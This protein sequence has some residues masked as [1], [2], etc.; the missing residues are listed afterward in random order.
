MN[1]WNDKN[2]A[3]I[4]KEE[5]LQYAMRLRAKF[6]GIE[7]M[8]PVQQQRFLTAQRKRTAE[9]EAA[10]AGAE[11][12]PEGGGG[13]L[14]S[15]DRGI[16]AK[17]DR[18]GQGR[19]RSPVGD[20]TQVEGAP[21]EREGQ[22]GG[23]TG[24]GDFGKQVT[25]RLAE[26][27]GQL[28]EGAD[29]AGEQVGAA[30]SE[31]VQAAYDAGTTP[32]KI[33][34]DI[35]NAIK[36]PDGVA[37]AVADRHPEQTGIKYMQ[38]NLLRVVEAHL[39]SRAP[40]A[41]D[42]SW[43]TFAAD[44]SVEIAKIYGLGG[45]RIGMGAAGWAADTALGVGLGVL[46]DPYDEAG[47][48]KWLDDA[49]GGD[50]PLLSWIADREGDTAAER[51]AK[52][53][54]E[55]VLV[56]LVG[57]GALDSILW[58]VQGGKKATGRPSDPEGL[59]MR[60]AIQAGDREA[61]VG[62]ATTMD[63]LGAIEA[64]IFKVRPEWKG[65]MERTGETGLPSVRP[66]RS[67]ETEQEWRARTEAIRTE[68]AKRGEFQPRRQ[69]ETDAEYAKR[70]QAMDAEAVP[71][72]VDVAILASRTEELMDEGLEP[73]AARAQA[74]E[75]LTAG[76]DEAADP[77][78]EA[79]DKRAAELMAEDKTGTLDYD[80]A[81]LAAQK[82]ADEGT[83]K[84]PEKP[85]EGGDAAPAPMVADEYRARAEGIQKLVT[86]L[87][88]EGAE[89]KA[90][91]ARLQERLDATDPV[92]K[93][94]AALKAGEEAPV[95]PSVVTAGE[96]LGIVPNNA[97]SPAETMRRALRISRAVKEGAA[98]KEAA[99]AEANAVLAD[100]AKAKTPEM[101]AMKRDEAAYTEERTLSDEGAVDIGLE[102][103]PEALAETPLWTRRLEDWSDDER[104]G[105][106]TRVTE[107][108]PKAE[109]GTT[110]GG[111]VTVRVDGDDYVLVGERDGHLLFDAH[112]W[113][114]PG[115]GDFI[116]Q[117]AQRSREL[118]EA[119]EA[120][121]MRF[122][123]PQV[124]PAGSAKGV[125]KLQEAV[126]G[127]EARL[128]AGAAE[129]RKAHLASLDDLKDRD[130]FV[131]H[132]TTPEVLDGTL[133]KTLE[134]DASGMP[135]MPGPRP[136]DVSASTRGS[137]PEDY[138]LHR[139]NVAQLSGYTQRQIDD[140]GIAAPLRDM[141]TPNWAK[142]RNSESVEAWIES[143]AEV[144][145]ASA[146]DKV[147]DM[148]VLRRIAWDLELPDLSPGKARAWVMALNDSANEVVAAA[149]MAVN[150]AAD[151]SMLWDMQV[152]LNRHR[153]ML[154]LLRGDRTQADRYFDGVDVTR[155]TDPEQDVA[156]LRARMEAEFGGEAQLVETANALNAKTTDDG[157]HELARTMVDPGGP[158]PMKRWAREVAT[159][160]KAGMLSGP[161][162]WV[163]IAL[164]NTMTHIN[165]IPPMWI[166]AGMRPFLRD[167]DD[168]V[169]YHE[170]MGDLTGRVA[171]LGMGIK[172]MKAEAE[173]GLWGGSR[174]RSK[175]EEEGLLKHWKSA[176]G[177]NR[178]DLGE[179][180]Y[181]EQA[182]PNRTF[183][184]QLLVG[185]DRAR[186]V[187][188][189][190]IGSIDMV[191]KGTAIG[192]Y[193]SGRAS[194]EGARQGLT[195][196]AFRNHVARRLRNPPEDW[197]EEAVKMG[198]DLTFMRPFSEN[199]RWM[200][201][202]MAKM[203]RAIER[204]PLLL[205]VMAM[206][207]RTAP[208]RSLSYA[209]DHTPVLGLAQ[210]RL[211]QQWAAGGR[212]KQMMIAR[213]LWGG[214]LFSGMLFGA[215]GGVLSGGGS[216]E[217][218]M[219][220]V[221]RPAYSLK[222]GDGWLGI[223]RLDPLGRLAGFAGDV[224]EIMSMNTDAD[225]NEQL[226]RVVNLLVGS[227]QHHMVD[228]SF[229]GSA[230]EF[231]E[232]LTGM[233]S[234]GIDEHWGGHLL[235]FAKRQGERFVPY[236]SLVRGIT[237]GVDPVYRDTRAVKEEGQEW[238]DYFMQEFRTIKAL[239]PGLSADL[240]PQFDQWGQP[241][242][243]MMPSMGE[244][245]PQGLGWS[246]LSPLA[247]TPDRSSP[248]QEAL[249]FAQWAPPPWEKSHKA[250]GYSD[251][252]RAAIAGTTGPL[253]RR[254]LDRHL[255][256]GAFDGY[257]RVQRTGN[258]EEVRAARDAAANE[259]KVLYN[260]AKR[261]GQRMVHGFATD[262]QEKR[263]DLLLRKAREDRAMRERIRLT[264]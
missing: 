261:Q 95:D 35:H 215:F 96:R 157:V 58:A 75:E 66:G 32:N 137:H 84:V 206:P 260:A 244:D 222:V 146:A 158:T 224:A 60:R 52:N 169:N 7:D 144:F 13:L 116:E 50:T 45:F 56:A 129:R 170:A 78:A 245:T 12:A 229:V 121:V 54:A 61:V 176:R 194:K 49:G 28:A 81:V 174:Y 119:S 37:G 15:L 34:E 63:E 172:M 40:E 259:V 171:G 217:R 11:A 139:D 33:L 167:S 198:E 242:T 125:S 9:E 152:A 100:G 14:G 69:G 204:H 68:L 82:E 113:E 48:A 104:T 114:D 47:I 71:D 188:F 183:A 203:G 3:A 23:E 253:F 115:P 178:L 159:T 138:R 213:Q 190:A 94:E 27:A 6:L 175:L 2:L 19:G 195:G 162:T 22:G 143:N 117:N 149:R 26:T 240:N 140:I 87:G 112:K 254:M 251:D 189:T 36:V 64:D 25:R 128:A 207:F 135:D 163:M 99:L 39:W 134:V 151:T 107:W 46:K 219:R 155:R 101:D 122:G 239:V 141:S 153:G 53:V 123:T 62:D 205:G 154:E 74:M 85:A 92:A 59:A 164:S 65:A 228:S 264:E 201:L 257:Y 55:E 211:R 196:I 103:D 256:S 120:P 10:A 227:V 136:L 237:R 126:E 5:R 236:G 179:R 182:D 133:P 24:M 105:F 200:L 185:L 4:D 20:D 131:L 218:H 252:E 38:P 93:R 21:Q 220:G 77:M 86:Q 145:P 98:P 168:L 51:T 181:A 246:M 221:E 91:A 209:L 241:R 102:A 202:P 110:R 258:A 232:G 130:L 70:Q 234:R 243:R 97:P 127:M 197:L 29:W 80:E 212:E 192:A 263:M 225:V 249:R 108:N 248:A 31:H 199:E 106:G 89:G 233:G 180:P 166:A 262:W 43:Q 124:E 90:V 8:D 67:R 148:A 88:K 76:A 238:D 184:K 30:I 255:A 83:L 247:W 150:T 79:V 118:L 191:A 186:R 161:R 1:G 226:M 187:P 250:V 173:A 214:M 230:A 17:Q 147:K 109:V 111:Q 142:V 160:A 223:E 210:K 208:A 165:A 16:G 44:V 177:T 42:P 193:V 73:D 231:A 235:R 156:R 72:E 18:R 216:R 41:V 57:R 132:R